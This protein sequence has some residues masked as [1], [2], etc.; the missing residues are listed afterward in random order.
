MLSC[1]AFFSDR[2]RR[3]P[4]RIMASRH[5]TIH[6]LEVIFK[7][8]VNCRLGQRSNYSPRSVS[9]SLWPLSRLVFSS[10][11]SMN[12]S[13]HR[14]ISSLSA[15][16][17]VRSTLLFATTS[18]RMICLCQVWLTGAEISFGIWLIIVF[19]LAAVWLFSLLSTSRPM[20]IESISSVFSYCYFSTDS[21][22]FRWCIRSIISFKHHRPALCWFHVWISSSV[23]SQRSPHSLWKASATN[24][25]WNG[26]MI[27]SWNSFWSFR[28]TAWDVVC[29]IWVERMH[30][31]RSI[32]NT[33]RSRWQ[34][35]EDDVRLSF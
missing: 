23:W 34:E 6:C 19:Q 12:A 13:A 25:I 18:K 2:I 16:W 9:S 30:W 11:S 32:R 29:S 22:S 21:R 15:A 7:S 8:I 28:I 17:T 4:S 10:F 24:R 14:N 31:M 5:L 1:V 35:G 3:W 20:S 26:S 33:V 27:F